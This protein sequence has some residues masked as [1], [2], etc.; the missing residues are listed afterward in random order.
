[1]PPPLSTREYASLSQLVDATRKQIQAIIRAN[2]FRNVVDK[3]VAQE[4]G[5]NVRELRSLCFGGKIPSPEMIYRIVRWAVYQEKFEKAP[6]RA[7][8]KPIKN[9]TAETAYINDDD[10]ARL[11]VLGRRLNMTTSALI[12]LAVAKLVRDNPPWVTIRDIAADVGQAIIDD[13]LRRDN[14][15]QDLLNVDLELVRRQSEKQ[16]KKE[17]EPNFYCGPEALFDVEI[18][19][20]GAIAERVWQSS[21]WEELE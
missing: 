6:S 10:Y 3:R 12:N 11:Q 9:Y 8:R 2:G 20:D 18:S 15:L 13:L 7:R 14:G 17:H 1:M 4:L 19:K 21:E 16:P 5:T